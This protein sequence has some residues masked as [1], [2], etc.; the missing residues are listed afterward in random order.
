MVFPHTLRL[1][2][3]D[4]CSTKSSFSRQIPAELKTSKAVFSPEGILYHTF[5]SSCH[6]FIPN[7][8]CHV[9][10]SCL[11]LSGS[12]SKRCFPSKTYT[13]LHHHGS[14]SSNFCLKGFKR[15]G[16]TEEHKKDDLFRSQIFCPNCQYHSRCWYCNIGFV[17]AA[18]QIHEMEVS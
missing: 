12:T 3:P 13:H 16:V 4:I 2:Q 18:I 7:Q 8:I 17:T 11:W 9:Q 15:S 14:Q 5:I 6:H 10:W 1:L